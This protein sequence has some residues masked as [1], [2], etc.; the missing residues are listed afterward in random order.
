MIKL[1]F[2]DIN[3]LKQFYSRLY[4]N[5]RSKLSRSQ[6]SILL[7][8]LK[9][10]DA[11]RFSLLRKSAISSLLLDN[12]SV[13]NLLNAG[14]IQG[15]NELNTY[16]ITAKG[17][18]YMEKQEGIIDEKLII[19]YI[20]ENFFTLLKKE[21]MDNTEKVIL[22]SLIL[23]RAFSKI[24]CVDLNKADYIKNGWLDVLKIAFDIVKKYKAYDDTKKFNKED[25]FKTRANVH[26]VSYLFRHNNKMKQKTKDIYSYTG[27]QQYYLNLYKNKKFNKNDLGYL[28]YILFKGNLTIKQ[29]ENISELCDKVSDDQ[30]LYLFDVAT[31]EFAH[32]KYNTVIK[33]ALID[34]ISK[35][36]IYDKL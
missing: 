36:S 6:K 8:F 32:P 20:Q 34:S 16:T 12:Q 17:V 30:S 22:L 21:K 7:Y 19:D 35:K 23:S 27:D 5:T 10:R 31:H 9:S 18:W 4:E 2:Q 15:M 11:T 26:I 24:S 14:Y 13:E 1:N 33:E 29:I 28:F 3:T 25:M